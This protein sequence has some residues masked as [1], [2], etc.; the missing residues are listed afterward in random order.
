MTRI[1]GVNLPINKRAVIALT[2]IH[3]IGPKFAAKICELVGLENTRRINSLT[4][5]EVIKIR[6]VISSDYLVEG[7]LR[8]QT[9]MNIKR[10]MDLGNYRGLRHRHGLPVRGQKTKTNG[11]TRKG[12]A[13]PI[14]RKK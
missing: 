9:S 13:V 3:G 4:E 14:S 7:E 12:K 10:M 6:E 8:R 1:A 5:Q 2:Y 11:R